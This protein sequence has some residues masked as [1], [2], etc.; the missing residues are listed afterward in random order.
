MESYIGKFIF[1]ANR[2]AK[3]VLS[4][5]ALAQPQQLSLSSDL[6]TFSVKQQSLT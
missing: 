2:K 5:P 6:D 4:C 1:L 3:T